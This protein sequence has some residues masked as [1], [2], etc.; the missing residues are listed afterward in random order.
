MPEYIDVQSSQKGAVA[1][2]WL[3]SA[4]ASNTRHSVTARVYIE[5]FLLPSTTETVMRLL[6][7]VFAFVYLR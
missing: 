2:M 7:F 6:P 1:V 5:H 4:V 3:N